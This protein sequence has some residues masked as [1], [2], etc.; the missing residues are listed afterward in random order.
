MHDLVQKIAEDKGKIYHLSHKTYD[1]DYISRKV[2]E[3]TGKRMLSGFFFVQIMDTSVNL[4]FSSTFY[5]KSL[6]VKNPNG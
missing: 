6:F 5:S 2:R 4:F 1:T 3:K